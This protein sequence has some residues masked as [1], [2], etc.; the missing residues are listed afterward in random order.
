M[1]L[2][3]TPIEYSEDDIETIKASLDS[4]EERIKETRRNIEK[5]PGVVWISIRNI[6]WSSRSML[7]FIQDDPYRERPRD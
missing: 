6:V 7:K 3:G 4:I 2:I 5:H 1:S